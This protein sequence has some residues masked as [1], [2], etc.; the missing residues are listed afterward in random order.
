[1]NLKIRINYI[2]MVNI[3]FGTYKLNNEELMNEILK[4][5]YT[6]GITKIDTAQLYRNEQ[7]ISNICKNGNLNFDICTKISKYESISYINNRIK[8]IYEIFDNNNVTEIMLHNPVDICYNKFLYNYDK[9]LYGVS[10]PSVD[11]LT[12]LHE[13]GIF[14]SFI[15]MEFHPFINVL[16]LVNFC[17]IH[18]IRIQG[19]TILSKGKFLSFVPLTKMAKKYNVT[20]VQLIIKWAS[21]FDIELCLSSKNKNHIDEWFIDYNWVLHT[22]DIAEINGYHIEYNHKF[23]HSDNTI[24][25]IDFPIDINEYNKFIIETL[26][27]DIIKMNNNE[28][29]S[30]II[31]HLKNLSKTKIIKGDNETYNRIIKELQEPQEPLIENQSK[32]DKIFYIIKNLRKYYNEQT[33]YKRKD[34]IKAKTCNLGT[35][36][37]VLNPE[38]MPI[39]PSD[40]KMFKPFFEYMKLDD[41]PETPKSF[42]K[43][44][45]FPDQRMDLCKQ[46]LSNDSMIEL[47]NIVKTSDK[48]DHFL[49]GNNKVLSDKDVMNE[50][51]EMVKNT[52]IK[53]LYLA[54]NDINA[55][56]NQILSKSLYNNKY[57]EALWLKRNPIH[58]GTYQLKCMLNNNDTL[59]L[60]DLHNTGIG[61]N[62]LLQLFDNLTN[63][64]L[65]HIYLD[66]NDLTNLD[67]FSNYIK[68]K[69][70]RLE[71][72]Y[73]GMNNFKKDSLD[74]FLKSLNG[75]EYLQR[76]CINSC[77][78]DDSF[79]FNLI[80]IPNLKMI[81]LGMYKSTND[82]GLHCNK[83]SNK[84]IDSI[85]EFIKRHN[86]L[87]YISLYSSDVDDNRIFDIKDNLSITLTKK[88][89]YVRDDNYINRELKHDKMLYN[90]DSIYRGKM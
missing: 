73:I 88:K 12:K 18:N 1:M 52:K 74:R 82:M 30:D 49:L 43:G 17:K 2:K 8:K 15:Q 29:I 39:T 35:N 21:T 34:L 70:S 45:F 51:C 48:V 41:I 62:G 7:I 20:V 28:R 67:P 25:T 13:N 78:L 40:T 60:L 27:D 37:S 61:N 66:A 65:K 69:N 36:Y 64:T 85:L 24:S 59:K 54:G 56:S 23:Y 55:V 57:V 53:T 19:H 5:V 89:K 46:G 9:T 80:N 81:D 16:V 87:E 79:D 6:K 77:N 75:N 32:L 68:S 71:S 76:L 83:F 47:C 58:T 14:P 10:N 90:I 63:N 42:I 44:T 84:S 38:A 72:I 4:Y 3:I 31:L 22:N 26:K 11:F 86:N 33:K 50:F